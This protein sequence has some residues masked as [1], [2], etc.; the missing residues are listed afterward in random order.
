MTRTPISE[1][2]SEIGKLTNLTSLDLRGTQISE[3]PSEIVKL[4]NL[5]KLYLSE[6]Q[7]S[8]L[9]SEIVKLTNLKFLDLSF[10]K[11]RTLPHEL[12]R[13]P[14]LQIL[15]LMNL[16]LPD[17]PESLL[18]LDCDFNFN[19]A[20]VYSFSKP[21][22]YIKNLKLLKQPV[23]L[24]LQPRELIEDYYRQSH[25]EIN[26]SKVIFL[27]SEGVGKTHTIKRILNDNHKITEDLKETPGISI[28]SKKFD[29]DD[30]SYRI[31]F[32]DFG[33]QEIMHAMHRCFLT[34]RTGYVVVVSTRFGDVN[35]QA[36]Y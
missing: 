8:E 36:R 11:I 19:Y 2:P 20:Y 31:S 17:L 13:M 30:L 22:I 5:T 28:T 29:T 33:G 16:V 9:P 7:I 21:G 34:D 14:A 1:L 23:S 15:G 12:G 25:T 10:T 32:W 18:A 4:T 35:K 6:T 3:L 24:F 27:G 26:E